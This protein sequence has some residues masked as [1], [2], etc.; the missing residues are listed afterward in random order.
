MTDGQMRQMPGDTAFMAKGQCRG[1]RPA[2]VL[3]IIPRP[4]ANLKVPVT[5]FAV[6]ES[7]YRGILATISWV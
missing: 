1:Q 3:R 2:P 6:D 5:N 7:P 4:K